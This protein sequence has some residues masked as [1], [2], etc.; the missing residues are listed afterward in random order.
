M[1]LQEGKNKVTGTKIKLGL[2]ACGWSFP[3]LVAGAK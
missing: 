1:Y 2:E 3:G